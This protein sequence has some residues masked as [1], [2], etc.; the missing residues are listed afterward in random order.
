MD[1]EYLYVSNYLREIKVLRSEICKVTENVFVNIHPVW[2][3]FR[4]TTDFGDYI[5][6]MPRARLFAFFSSHPIVAEL[7]RKVDAGCRPDIAQ[8]HGNVR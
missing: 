5:M 3:H 1:G 2:I 6:F 7:R 4:R 8:G